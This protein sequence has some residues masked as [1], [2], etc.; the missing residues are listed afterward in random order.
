MTSDH[1]PVFASFDI[2]VT[3]Q[4]LGGCFN[5]PANN[6]A[7]IIFQEVVAEVGLWASYKVA[8][9]LYIVCGSIVWWF[10]HT[11]ID[12]LYI[13]PIQILLSHCKLDKR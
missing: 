2:G 10:G 12:T 7:Q 11:A 8:T 13:P 5:K 3:N 9:E 1:K 6:S 4:A